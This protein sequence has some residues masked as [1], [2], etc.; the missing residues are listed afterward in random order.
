M[1]DVTAQLIWYR[2]KENYESLAESYRQFSWRRVD[3]LD[4]LFLGWVGAAF[5]VVGLVNLYLRFF[6]VPKVL[7]RRRGLDGGGGDGRSVDGQGS[8]GNAGG[9]RG[10]ETAQW[11]NTVVGWLCENC[12]RKQALVELWAKALTEEARK[13]TVSSAAFG[14]FKWVPNPYEQ[15][16]TCSNSRSVPCKA[17]LTLASYGN[18]AI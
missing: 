13:Y 9:V 3:I 14:V 15:Q 18:S 6:G 8:V 5:L 7:Q 10:G 12:D 1:A 16:R 4:M 17:R 11:I 2:L